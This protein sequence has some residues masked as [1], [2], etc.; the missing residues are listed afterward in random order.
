L[1]TFLKMNPTLHGYEYVKKTFEKLGYEHITLKEESFTQDMQYEDALRMLNVLLPFAREN[2][3]EFGAKLSNTL[4]VVNDKGLLPTDEMYMSGRA[5]YPLTINLAKKLTYE[6]N[7]ELKISYAGG[8]NWFNVEE[9]FE[10]G[11]RPITIATDLLK[12]GGYYRLNQMAIKLEDLMKRS[13]PQK[14]DLVKLD[15]LADN[16]I[17]GK[18]YHR[19]ARS[20]LPMK[21]N[22]NLEMLKCFTAPCV[23]TCPIHQD[24]PEYIRLIG[25]KRYLEAF[26]L[27][28][29]KN[30]LPHITGYI[31]DHQCMY[32]CVRIDYEEP[33]LIRELKRVA[34][35]T[36]FTEYSKKLSPAVSP[37]GIKIAV[38]G[39]GPAG[40]ASACF[41]AR[42]GFDVTV[43][44][45]TPKIGGT[46]VHT[47]PRFR[48]PQ[49]AIERDVE[50]IKKMGVKFQLNSN[51]NINISDLKSKG[52][53][54]INLAIGASRSRMLKLEG[55]TDSILGAIKFL[56]NWNKDPK[57]L[58][59]GRN[60]AVI[61]GGNSAM[62]GARAA[63]K[64][65]G[66]EKVYIIY[67][68]TIKEMPADRE[69]L[70]NAL[71]DGVIFKELLNPVALNNG[72]L[73]CQQMKL[74][75]PD[76]SGRKRPVPIQGKFTEMEI[77]T[78]LSAI[79]EIVDYDL[80]SRNGIEIDKKGNICVNECNETSV[81]NVFISGDARRG[82][83]T[84]VESIAD[85]QS[86]ADGILAKENIDRERVE[87]ENCKFDYATRIKDIR[88]KKGVIVP[89]VE[90]LSN[91]E[92]TAAETRRCLECNFICNKC[93][94]VCPNRAN[95]AIKVA[96][97]Q[98]ENQILHL[99]G[100]CN[101]CGNCETFC[102]Y[103]GAPYKD[104]FTLFWNEADMEENSNNGFLLL[105]EKNN[106]TFKL[107]LDQ[108]FYL[109]NMNSEGELTSLET[110]YQIKCKQSFEAILDVIWTTYKKYRYV[111][112]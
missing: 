2:G 106:I 22:K 21:I 46:V 29:S 58:N 71:K 99:D 102:P 109:L 98:D 8:A 23:E 59:P 13:I 42:D 82:P 90:M 103:N 65:P 51:E 45:K 91:D 49:K 88:A 100:F 15:K 84:V 57:A 87:P 77:D 47:I 108:Q 95:I 28:L 54:Y 19:E 93:V 34:A 96:G 81:E 33:V 5:L 26:E 39:A 112:R 43:F 12:P 68:R 9:L 89:T 7:G 110:E 79:G 76:A 1:H 63:R 36:G 72:I 64:T 30:P 92:E 67:R 61:G 44:E 55:D 73:K 85:A 66:V 70:E 56:Q 75:E 62:D 16:A 25:E 37:N 48:L 111:F 80:L 97:F 105:S 101:E 35:E 60:I 50:L 3:V 27:I 104:K 53:K 17:F 20:H 69:E 94:E 6:F 52:F 10:I 40:L 32:K 24:V 18:R 83:S 86:V 11:I 14:I 41:L 38:I 107:R 74:G 78:V 31:C 4:A